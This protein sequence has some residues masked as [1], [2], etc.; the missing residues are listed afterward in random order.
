VSK[1]EFLRVL[2]RSLTLDMTSLLIR[3]HTAETPTQGLN[4]TT[5]APR[6]ASQ[7]LVWN[8][9]YLR[10]IE[11]DPFR[12]ILPP[13]S[14]VEEIIVVQPGYSM[15][16]NDSGIL[17]L[18]ARCTLFVQQF[19]AS[20]KQCPWTPRKLQILPID[21]PAYT[22]GRPAVIR[23]G[24]ANEMT[25]ARRSDLTQYGISAEID[26]HSGTYLNR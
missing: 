17:Q 21:D 4:I 12:D 7:D 6:T 19:A 20:L 22:L 25:S 1:S 14:T 18:E 10:V 26:D 23:V 11:K 13:L 2:V 24:T 15:Y 9:Y 5:V 3:N 16:T 8:P